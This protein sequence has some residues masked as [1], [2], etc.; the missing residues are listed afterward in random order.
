MTESKNQYDTYNASD[1]KILEGLEAVR[2]RP[3][4]YIGSTG[5]LGLHHLL[6]EVVD[7]SIDEAL[8]GY[9]DKITVTIH[10][11]NSISVED[12]GRGIPVE[13]HPDTG[14]PACEVVLTTLH[15]GGKFDNSTYKISGGLHGVGVS[16]VNALSEKLDILIKRNGKIYKQSYEYGKPTNDLF[17]DNITCNEMNGTTICFKPDRSI[18]EDIEYNIDILTKRLRE[19]SFLNKGLIIIIN[20]ERNDLH[21]EYNYQGGILDFVEY[22]NRN[23]TVLHDDII[24]LEEKKGD[25]ILDV[26]IQYN[27]SYSEN[28]FTYVNNINTVDG[29]THLHGFRTALTRCMNTFGNT[30]GLFK[31]IKDVPVGEDVREGLAAVIN[32]KLPN[33]QFEGQTKTKLGNS[34]IKGIVESIIL[35]KLT[36]YLDEHPGVGKKILSKI[37]EASKA[38]EAARKA[39]ETIRKSNL[40]FSTLPGKLAD[41][42]EKDPSL[43]E[44]FLV[45]GDSAGGSAK[46][47]RDRKYQAILPLRGKILNV[48]KARFDKIIS[49]E[50][51]KLIITALGTG[52]GDEN[53]NINKLR[54]HKIIIMTDADVDGS[55][56]RTLLLT[57][58]FRQMTQII[59]RGHLFIAQPPLFKVKRSKNYEEYLLNEEDLERYLLK[60]GIEEVTIKNINNETININN[61][62][63]DI[64]K[65]NYRYDNIV[66]KYGDIFTEWL[67]QENGLQILLSK[68][69]QEINNDYNRFIQIK[70]NESLSVNITIIDNTIN[71]EYSNNTYNKNIQIEITSLFSKDIQELLKTYNKMNEKFQ[72]PIFI[73]E[74]GSTKILSFKNLYEITKFLSIL[75]KSNNAIQRY[76]G[77]GEMNPEQLWKTTMDP[78]NRT[79]LKVNINDNFDADN[80]FNI[81]MG[82]QVEPRRLFI[83]ENALLVN[84]LDV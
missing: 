56:I 64:R 57:F 58:F 62:I 61:N 45:E 18:F 43:C 40:E 52:I 35:D 36:I 68:N 51:I 22:I 74:N 34:D 46:Q 66:N 44:L 12:N 4:M 27:D 70:L 30:S 10:V 79:M 23:K 59:E 47:G 37:L 3:A 75:G 55:H 48:E 32:L 84:N 11:D 65:I 15:A 13:I 72:W 14:R 77:L 63:D 50:E 41:C 7:N 80:I 53:Y 31:N 81:L 78:N 71:I 76:K 5:A 24:H 19:L 60:K 49:S 83:N 42:Q 2:K 33:P 54:Y 28:V 17:E 20:D 8:A 38:R 21:Y 67:I 39:R 6:Y 29:G 26:A 69:I 9:C 16:C 73:N 82:D 1:I 25:I